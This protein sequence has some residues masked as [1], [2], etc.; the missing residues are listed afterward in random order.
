MSNAIHELSL[1]WTLKQYLIKDLK[2]INSKF[3]H[4]HRIRF[5]RAMGTSTICKKLNQFIYIY[6]CK[7]G[8]FVQRSIAFR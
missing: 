4:N 6:I 8:N 1:L 7:M 5:N 3:A 2:H